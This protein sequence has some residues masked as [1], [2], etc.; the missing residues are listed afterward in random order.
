MFLTESLL[1]CRCHGD[2]GDREGVFR[3]VGDLDEVATLKMQSMYHAHYSVVLCVLI[4]PFNP[5]ILSLNSRHSYHKSE[6]L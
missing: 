5:L 3:C 1:K 6:Q 2:G 4:N